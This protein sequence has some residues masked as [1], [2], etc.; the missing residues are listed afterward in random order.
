[1]RT[2]IKELIVRKKLQGCIEC[3]KCVASCP[4][5]EMF[6]D[7]SYEYSARGIIGKVL[8]GA[9]WKSRLGG[10]GEDILKDKSIWYC[11]TCDVCTDG[12]PAGVKFCEFIKGLRQIAIE[13][14]VKEL[15]LFCKRCGNY[16]LPTH[17]LEYLR[18]K[19]I[20]PNPQSLIPNL[21]W[22]LLCPKCRK[23][24]I[25]QKIKELLPGNKKITKTIKET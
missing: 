7:F 11:L 19:I 25:S 5:Y 1:M 18:E 20:T 24:E 8:F 2:N 21:D 17:T 12:C 9:K 23:Y 16:F 22:L 14:G 3:G 13:K 6:K 4:M 10:V 15:G